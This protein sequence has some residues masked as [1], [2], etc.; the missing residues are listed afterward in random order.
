MDKKQIGFNALVDAI[1]REFVRRYKDGAIFSW[2]EE[3]NRSLQEEPALFCFLGI[4][5]HP[6]TAPLC[7][8]AQMDEWDI[9]AS[10]YV[11]TDGKIVMDEC[12]L[13]QGA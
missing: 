9:Y 7:L 4:D 2:G 6:E 3:E 5:L 12:R 11:L 8:S 10:C 1:G 13:P